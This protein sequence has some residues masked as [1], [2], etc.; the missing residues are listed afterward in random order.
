MNRIIPRALACAI[1]LGL[2]PLAMTP[3]IAAPAAP[4]TESG[5]F[6]A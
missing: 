1:A 2:A 5:R 6:A 4:E 3:T